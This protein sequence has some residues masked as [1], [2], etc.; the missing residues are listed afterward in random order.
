MPKQ[1]NK[2]RMVATIAKLVSMATDRRRR[3]RAEPYLLFGAPP[4]DVVFIGTADVADFHRAVDEFWRAD[5]SI[6]ETVPRDEVQGKVVD[7]VRQLLYSD[8]APTADDIDRLFDGLRAQEEHEWQ[9]FRPLHGAL[10]GEERHPFWAPQQSRRTVAR[11]FLRPEKRHR[12]RRLPS[13][14]SKE[15]VQL[16]PFTIYDR[17]AHRDAIVATYPNCSATEIDED[18]RQLEPS[19]TLVSVSVTARD[20]HR[21]VEHAD[22]Y[23]DQFAQIVRYMVGR[24]DDQHDVGVFD[25]DEATS[26]PFFVL[27]PTYHRPLGGWRARGAMRPVNLASPH[28]TRPDAGYDRIW[29]IVGN[30]YCGEV[31]GEDPLQ[32]RLLSA[33][34]W[35]GKGARDR[36]LGRRFVQV[37]FALEALFTS[38]DKGVPVTDRLAEYAAFVWADDFA[39]RDR[40]A[41]LT[42]RLY[43]KRS[44]IAHGRESAVSEE[45]VNT[46]FH[47]VKN[48]VVALLTKSPLAEMTEMA[49]LERWARQKRYS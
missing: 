35:L 10:T 7:L 22:V 27:A 8:G 46:A 25:H 21:A 49:E 48:L 17:Q 3:S 20:Y 19:R 30:I 45:D 5:P 12:L 13:S 32:E 41:V 40:I 18:L 23:F 31:Q 36:D 2:K 39:E 11:R 37:M 9:V 16:G 4:Y 6:E 15:P 24:G 28:F 33:V 43:S 26:L 42:R 14:H 1:L 44:D 34:I 38:Q 29:G 47:L